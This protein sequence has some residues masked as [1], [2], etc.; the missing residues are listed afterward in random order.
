MNNVCRL[1]AAALLILGA[2]GCASD[3]QPASQG[4]NNPNASDIPWN[5][6]QTW[7]GQGMMGGFMQQQGST[8][9]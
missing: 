3:S 4:Q 5:R 2:C 8:G 1:F 6:P 7:E 9:H